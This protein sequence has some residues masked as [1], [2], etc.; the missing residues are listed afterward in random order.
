MIFPMF[1]LRVFYV[2]FMFFHFVLGF[3]RCFW[4]GVPGL[5][6]VLCEVV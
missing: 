1:F 2:F 4:N 3:L 6:M 5:S